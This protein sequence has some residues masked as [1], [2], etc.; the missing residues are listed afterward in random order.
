MKFRSASTSSPKQLTE[1][2]NLLLAKYLTARNREPSLR[3]W[4]A[5]FMMLTYIRFWSDGF[6]WHIE[7]L[8]GGFNRA[9]VPIGTKQPWLSFFQNVE[10][11]TANLYLPSEESKCGL[12]KRGQ[13]D[14][15]NLIFK[16]SILYSVPVSFP[17]R[18]Y[19]SSPD[20]YEHRKT[21][22]GNRTSACPIHFYSFD[23]NV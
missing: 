4:L 8:V 19:K 23:P 17:F 12:Q 11:R 1:E 20:N 15:P 10:M 13:R 16:V 14:E 9:T 22:T 7:G 21:D 2:N 3:T 6:W 5:V 18:F